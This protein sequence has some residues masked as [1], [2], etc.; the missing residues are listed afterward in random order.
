MWCRSVTASEGQVDAEV[1]VQ[2][3]A[4]TE[5]ND[6]NSQLGSEVLDLVQEAHAAS[7]GESCMFAARVT[8][9]WHESGNSVP[10]S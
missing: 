6:A 3:A 9:H 4:V 5:P 10:H 7:S 1:G 2:E 8:T